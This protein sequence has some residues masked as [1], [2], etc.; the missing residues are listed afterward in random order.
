MKSIK[1]LVAILL[2]ISL[3]GCGGGPD[4]IDTDKMQADVSACIAGNITKAAQ[5]AC[6][7]GA[8]ASW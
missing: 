7:T 4:P 6:I 8:S 5:D 3:I 2:F 1:L